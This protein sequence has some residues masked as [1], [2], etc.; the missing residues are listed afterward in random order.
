MYNVILYY[1]NGLLPIKLRAYCWDRLQA[2]KGD[3]QI[4]AVSPDDPGAGCQWVKVPYL[5]VT[6][7]YSVYV[8]ML[9]GLE[10]LPDGAYIHTA[11]HD[12]LYP[13]GYFDGQHCGTGKLAYQ[14]NVLR[15]SACG[16][17]PYTEASTP[18]SL[19]SCLSGFAG[20]IAA[21]LRARLARITSGAQNYPWCE[22]D[23]LPISRWAHPAPMLDIRHGTNCTG[24]RTHGKYWA[25]S[26]HWGPAADIIRDCGLL[27]PV[28]APVDDGAR[29]IRTC[30]YGDYASQFRPAMLAAP[31][32]SYHLHTDG[33]NAAAKR[34]EHYYVLCDNSPE[35]PPRHA[36]RRFKFHSDAG[37]AW[38]IYHDDNITVTDPDSLIAWC[39]Q[40]PADLYLFGHNVRRCLYLEADYCRVNRLLNEREAMAIRDQT[41]VYRKAG[42]PHHAGLY[43]LGMFVVRNSGRMD[44]FFAAVR[45]EYKRW[46]PQP[47]DQLALPYVLWQWRDRVRP[48]K[49][50]G[51]VYNNP[52]STFHPREHVV[53][54]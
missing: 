54:S 30:I 46:W 41:G 38:S 12:C 11:E 15:L 44:D 16:F 7:P 1:T 23:E 3:A 53:A 21:I 24:T 18:F 17:F 45:S 40:L 48:A 29:L 52:W 32:Y 39:Q 5:P 4:I 34:P 19:L 22:P 28:R 36:S 27:S 6:S 37:Y 8:T 43:E 25:Q 26:E 31:G 47:N 49:L 51:T 9:A 33:R 20:D 13:P 2:I 50:P 42:Y 14:T 35:N 10:T